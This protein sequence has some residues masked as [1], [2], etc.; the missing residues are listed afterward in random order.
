MRIAAAQTA[1]VWGDPAAT[2][3][4]VIEWIEKAANDGVDLVAFGEVFL[5]GYPFWVPRTDGARWEAD[6]Q[7]AAYAY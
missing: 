4:R 7:K 2:T 5:S 6:D 1:S 3:E